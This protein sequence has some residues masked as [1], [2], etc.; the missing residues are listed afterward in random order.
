MDKAHHTMKGYV[1]YSKFTDLNVNLIL[2]TTLTETARIISEHQG[3][4]KLTHEINH[5]KWIKGRG[6]EKWH[7]TLRLTGGLQG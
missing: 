7:S 1:L 6:Q 2:Q 3:P 5:H 4:A